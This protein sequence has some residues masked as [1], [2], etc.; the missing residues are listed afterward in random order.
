M[1]KAYLPSVRAAVAAAVL[2]SSLLAGTSGCASGGGAVSTA[3][4]LQHQSMIDVV[5]LRERRPFDALK[6][7]VATP[8]KWEML[9]EHRTALY[10]HQQWRSPTRR[11]G[12]GVAH[13]RLPFP[14]AAKPLVWLAK[15]EYTKKSAEG[16][17]IREWSDGAGRQWFEAENNRYHISGYA[18]VHGTDAWFVYCGYKT[19]NGV[20][21]AELNLAARCAETVLPHPIAGKLGGAPVARAQ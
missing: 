1:G 18:V 9:P 16:R 6:A 4:L 12:V 19:A 13:V 17:L 3:K 7:S 11:T 20:D 5:G 14:M 2:V 8:V 10:L 15:Q 21:P